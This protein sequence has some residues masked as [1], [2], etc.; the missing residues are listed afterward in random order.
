MSTRRDTEL[1]FARINSLGSIARFPDP[2]GTC[3]D[4]H[5]IAAPPDSRIHAFGW[6][7]ELA[8]DCMV[9]NTGQTRAQITA[10]V[11]RYIVQPGQATAYKIGGLKIKELSSAIVWTCAD[12]ITR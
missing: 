10:E 4:N 8:I 12:S 6:T 7:R 9:A 2:I 3:F 1:F 11:D 5:G